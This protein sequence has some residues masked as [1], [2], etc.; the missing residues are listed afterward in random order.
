VLCEK[1]LVLSDDDYLRLAQKAQACQR[2]VFAVHNWKYAPSIQKALAWIRAG[3]LGPIWQAD[4]YVLRDN[5][6]QG[7]AQGARE[8]NWRQ[9]PSV[10]GGGILVD[11]GWHAFYLLLNLL[12]AEP[13]RLHAQMQF[14][15][16]E[17]PNSLEE[18][19]EVVVQFPAATGGIHLTWRAPLRRNSLYIQ[20]EQGTLALDDDRLILNVRGQALEEQRFPA[21][22]AGSHH[23]DWFAAL[24]VDFLDE[25]ATPT[26]KGKNFREAGW[27][28]ALT[29][30]AYA[31][32]LQGGKS[33]PVLFPGSLQRHEVLHEV[34]RRP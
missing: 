17:S 29:K 32:Q 20:G 2:T 27:C 11:H 12:G 19:A 31:S 30:T 26:A 7:T 13:Q 28:T 25:I 15:G 4:L 6:C 16:A 3:R 1:P 18:V 23:A 5:V 14:G 33:L 21:L 8:A 22:S 9:D 10:S 34:I 24:L